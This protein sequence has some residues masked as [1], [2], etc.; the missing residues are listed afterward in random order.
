MF[1]F[2]FSLSEQS[3]LML[4]LFITLALVG[5]GF[6]YAMQQRHAQREMSAIAMQER[7][8]YRAMQQ[9]M[10]SLEKLRMVQHDAKNEL[11]VLQ[12]FLDRGETEQAL[13]YARELL[14]RES[15]ETMTD[16][17]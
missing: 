16:F 14:R 11:L 12:G 6:A 8:L 4:A 17:V 10:Q 5:V 3:I 13:D 9:E 15:P 1:E 2:S 7:H